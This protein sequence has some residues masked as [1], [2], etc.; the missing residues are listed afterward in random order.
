MPFARTRPELVLD[1]V[2][3]NQL[4]VLC[5]ARTA[6]VAEVERAQVMLAY[7]DGE[8]V[9]AIARRMGTNRPKVE[10]CIDKA[11]QL[12]PVAALKDLPRAGRPATITPEARAWVVSLACVQPKKLGY[13]Y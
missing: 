9:S 7:A 6:S 2:A 11:L 1:P 12:G 4:L 5:R 8:T 10:R 13:S 3:R